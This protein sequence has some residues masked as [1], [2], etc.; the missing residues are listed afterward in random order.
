MIEVCNIEI[1]KVV[2]T[3]FGKIAQQIFT[4]VSMWI[5]KTKSVSC[6]K[7]FFGHGEEISRLTGTSLPNTVKMTK[8]VFKFHSDFFFDSSVEIVS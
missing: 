5:N 1:N 3:I 8:S 6:F 2:D 7:V 4:E